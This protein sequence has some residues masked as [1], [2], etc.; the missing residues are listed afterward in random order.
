MIRDL[1][2]ELGHLVYPSV[3]LDLLLWCLLKRPSLE[4]RTVWARRGD[5]G[6][7]ARKS[8]L[9]SRVTPN[10]V[11]LYL[12]LAAWIWIRPGCCLSGLLSF[13]LPSQVFLG[14]VCRLQ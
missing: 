3:G 11:V 10:P 4:D 6:G 13:S 12:D 2:A 5:V 7:A 1:C 8:S 9:C 14:R